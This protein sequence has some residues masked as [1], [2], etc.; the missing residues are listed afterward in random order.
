MINYPCEVKKMKEVSR[1]LL[2]VII[3]SNLSYADLEKKTGIAKSSIQRYATGKTKKIPIDAVKLIADATKSSA[4]WIMGWEID[5][6]TEKKNDILTD[7][8]LRLQSDDEFREI[9][10]SI[11]NASPELLNALK[12]FIFA[13]KQ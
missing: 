7:I 11:Y 4:D 2:K 6:K 12:A 5:E 9:T 1:R 3:D 10:E 8:V 13:F